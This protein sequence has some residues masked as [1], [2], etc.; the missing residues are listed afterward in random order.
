MTGGYQRAVVVVP[1]EVDA[2]RGDL[3]A[4]A[5]VNA[6]FGMCDRYTWSVSSELPYGMN[7]ASADQLGAQMRDLLASGDE[8]CYFVVKAYGVK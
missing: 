6:R 2:S 7:V 4:D 5:L 3:I 1:G 8:G